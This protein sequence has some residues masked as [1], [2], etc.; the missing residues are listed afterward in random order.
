MEE[1][2]LKHKKK[3]IDIHF[4][5]LTMVFQ[6]VRLKL[7]IPDL[8]LR[9]LVHTMCN[10]CFFLFTYFLTTPG[11]AFSSPS[12][13]NGMHNTSIFDVRPPTLLSSPA[14]ETKNQ[15]KFNQFRSI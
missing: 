2:H 8:S 7:T 12:E 4:S 1:T 15:Q 10:S 5:F 14:S 9:W 11:P 6:F 13:T 3:I